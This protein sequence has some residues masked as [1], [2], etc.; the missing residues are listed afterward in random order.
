MSS[1]DS[2]AEWTMLGQFDPS[3]NKVVC[4]LHVGCGVWWWCVLA[5]CQ[6]LFLYLFLSVHDIMRVTPHTVCRLSKFT[7]RVDTL[8]GFQMV[9]PHLH[10][11]Q[12]CLAFMGG[13]RTSPRHQNIASLPLIS[14]CGRQLLAQPSTPLV[15]VFSHPMELCVCFFSARAHR[16][17]NTKHTSKRNTMYAPHTRART[18]TPTPTQCTTAICSI[19][20]WHHSKING[21]SIVMVGLN[22]EGTDNEL[23][24]QYSWDGYALTGPVATL[25]LPYPCLYGMGT[26]L[27]KINK[28]INKKKN[29][30]LPFPTPPYFG[31][32]IMIM[33][34]VRVGTSGLF[35]GMTIL[36]IWQH[37][38]LSNIWCLKKGTGSLSPALI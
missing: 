4:V 6:N 3:T 35:S 8:I 11:N 14:S 10:L 37:C 18:P 15:Y 26:G 32:I 29:L 31:F 22:A 5:V 25:Y 2:L 7:T 17:Q 12:G 9:H 1:S 16:T 34:Q 33:C 13:C 36:G 27:K 23:I 19:A 30:P 21:T 38:T 28:E 20:G 24:A